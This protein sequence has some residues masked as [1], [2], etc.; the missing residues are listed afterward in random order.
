L[1]GNKF[2]TGFKSGAASGGIGSLV[3]DASKAL[4][5][6]KTLGSLSTPAKS[7]ATSALVAKALNRPF[8]FGQAA[9]NAAINYGFNQ[10][11]QAAGFT[12]SQQKNLLHL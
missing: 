6:D 2:S 12:P 10:A 9:Q 5:L 3:G 8:D 1:T 7:L 11:G 4:G